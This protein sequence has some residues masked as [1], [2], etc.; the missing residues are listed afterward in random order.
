M[1]LSQRKTKVVLEVYLEEW[2]NS[3]QEEI[4]QPRCKKIIQWEKEKG[5][6]KKLKRSPRS[7]DKTNQKKTAMEASAVAGKKGKTDKKHIWRY[8]KDTAFKEYKK[9]VQEGLHRNWNNI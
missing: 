8:A 9:W 2:L 7:L 1:G 5:I 6:S 4:Q 3:F